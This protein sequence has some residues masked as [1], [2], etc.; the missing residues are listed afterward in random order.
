MSLPGRGSIVQWRARLL[1][2]QKGPGSRPSGAAAHGLWPRC[3]EQAG[4]LISEA[5]Q[6]QQIGNAGEKD[7]RDRPPWAGAQPQCPTRSLVRSKLSSFPV[8][9][10]SASLPPE[11]VSP[12]TRG[13]R[14]PGA[15]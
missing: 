10:R 8:H 4:C 5:E 14:V 15:P 7:V 9:L 13:G 12:P 3:P 6:Q 11:E 1:Y 2:T